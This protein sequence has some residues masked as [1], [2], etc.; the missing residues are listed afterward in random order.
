MFLKQSDEA[1]ENE[2]ECNP[3][4]CPY[5]DGHFDRINDAMYDLLTHEDH[6]TGKT[7]GIC[8]KVSGVSVRIQS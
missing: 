1:R 2:A 7:A 5:A 8:R 4:V 6:F 3:D